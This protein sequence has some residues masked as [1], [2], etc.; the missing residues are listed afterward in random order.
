MLHIVHSHQDIFIV[1]VTWD[2]FDSEHGKVPLDSAG[3]DKVNISRVN[4]VLSVM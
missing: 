2:F 4:V 3:P 1:R